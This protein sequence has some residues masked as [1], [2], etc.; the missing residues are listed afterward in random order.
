MD[1]WTDEHT[2]HIAASAP[3]VP[4]PTPLEVEQ[5]WERIR[6]EVTPT[7]SRRKARLLI[8]AGVTAVAVGVSGVAAAGILNARTGRYADDEVARLSGPGEMI[9]INGTDYATVIA[10]ESAD[11]PFPTEA[12]RR[13]SIDDQV[14][15]DTRGTG[16]LGGTTT[17]GIRAEQA[18]HAICSWANSWAVATK[19]DDAAARATA[20]DM[21]Q[22]APAW[23]AITDV[24]QEQRFTPT[25]FT[26][27]DENGKETE[28]D[29]LDSTPFAWVPLVAKAASGTDL[30]AM[31][32]PFVEWTR[33]PEALVPDLPQA[34]PAELRS[35]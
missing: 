11:I 13:I 23:P 1:N 15:L 31:G 35:R 3:P 8:G 4:E 29:F 10:E 9:D 6:G 20:I 18:R 21:L 12:A 33:C 26:V 22:A 34:I 25:T 2:R 16:D 5:V 7:R 28:R 27:A 14:G 32:R 24:D 30:E 19:T 17:G